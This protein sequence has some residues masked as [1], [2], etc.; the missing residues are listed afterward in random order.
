M[1][2]CKFSSEEN[3]KMKVGAKKRNP[4]K[5]M[6]RCYLVDKELDDWLQSFSESESEVSGRNVSK[7]EVLRNVIQYYID[8]ND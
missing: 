1:V 6:P 8:V 5:F 4:K 7:S 2:D 3:K